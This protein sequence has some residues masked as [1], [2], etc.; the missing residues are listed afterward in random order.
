V[1]QPVGHHCPH[2]LQYLFNIHLE[3]DILI[4]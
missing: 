3:K 4:Y 2:L 1:P